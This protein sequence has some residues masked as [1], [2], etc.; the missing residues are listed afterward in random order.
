M[1]RKPKPEVTAVGTKPEIIVTVRIGDKVLLQAGCNRYRIE[2]NEL[3]YWYKQSSEKL[4]L[5][6]R[7]QVFLPRE[8]SV[9]VDRGVALDLG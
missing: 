8:C 1:V 7:V 2:A 6:H 9:S 3:V 4:E 5:L